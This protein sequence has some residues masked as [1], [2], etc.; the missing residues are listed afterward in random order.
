MEK[1]LKIKQADEV[2]AL[3]ITC[4]EIRITGIVQG[5]GF[6][7]HVY[8]LAMK[9]GIKGWVLNSSA[10]VVIEA[11]G[12]P[13][14]VDGFINDLVNNPPP[15]AVIKSHQMKQIDPRGFP[16]FVI[17]KSESEEE[18]TVMISPDIAICKDCRREILDS[19]DRRYRYPFT[20]CTNCGPRFTIIKDIPYDR[21]M[22]TMAPFPMC[23]LCQ[24]EYENPMHRRFHAQPNACADCGPTITVVDSNGEPVDSEPVELLKKGYILAVKSLGGFHLAADAANPEVVQALR[25]RKRRDAKPFAVMARNMEAIERYCEVSPAEEEWLTSPRAPIV[26]LKSKTE[27]GLPDQ[28]IHPG[29]GTLG[30]ML[31]YTPLHFLLFDSEL[32]LL[33][34]T[35]ANISDEPL[36]INNQDALSLLAGIA[37]YFVLHNREIFNPCDDSV[38]RVIPPGSPHFMRRAR[39]FV[40]LGIK[41]PVYGRPVLALGGE[42]KNTFCITREDQAFLSQHWGDLDHYLNYSR[43]LESIPRFARMLNVEPEVIVH[44]L[45]PGYQT[46]RW[47]ISQT[48]LPRIAV[49][50]HYAHLASAMADNELDGETLGIICDGT[51]W[52]TD[53]AVWGGEVLRGDYSSFER[54][55]HFKYVPLPGGDLT[56]KRP[57]RMALV[58]LLEALGEGAMPIAER[59]LPELKEEERTLVVEQ[60]KRGIKV[61][62]TSSCGRLFDAVS[63]ITGI[64]SLNHYEGQAAIELEERADLSDGRVYSYL[65]EKEHGVWIM[66]VLPMW[67]DIIRDLDSGITAPV[68]AGRFHLTLIK[69]MGDVLEK[70]REETGLNRVVLSGG[71]FHNRILL[72]GLTDLLKTQGFE[73]YQHRQVPTGDGGLALG[74][75]IIGLTMFNSNRG[76]DKCV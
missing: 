29:I 21:A 8:R 38:M 39:G 2:M 75:A 30:A 11:E 6:R 62:P 68:I 57:Y 37:D 12:N 71:V 46:T 63:A 9:Y 31:P 72:R 54:V 18:K 24:E 52:G 64:C 19:G 73:V 14:T 28:Y 43:F 59:L 45:H 69:L 53:D 13:D 5:V 34:M 42:M 32:D 7:P 74:Q 20:N 61:V 40:P 26:I 3:N 15:L 16:D 56:I 65:L 66:N 22:T 1:S 47:A 23:P 55:A 50:H 49:Q 25:V 17:K 60:I 44:D 48:D 33:I 10:G 41:L 76:E 58:Y 70:A 51:G 36:I 67:K 35:S 4:Y 27:T